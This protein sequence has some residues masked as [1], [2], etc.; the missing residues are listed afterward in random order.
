[1]ERVACDAATSVP[2]RP[3]SISR[4]NERRGKRRLAQTSLN[5]SLPALLAL[6]LRRTGALGRK[7]RLAATQCRLAVSVRVSHAW[8]RCP[9][10]R[11]SLA[12]PWAKLRMV[13]S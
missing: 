8:H 12:V 3:D 4:Q 10:A 5:A 11:P 1:M 9:L 13:E 2:E 6:L 7:D